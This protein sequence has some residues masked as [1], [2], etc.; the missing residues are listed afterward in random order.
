[1]PISRKFLPPIQTLQAFEAVARLC[2]FTLAADELSLTQ[3]AVSRQISTLETQLGCLLLTR[4]PRHVTLTPEGET[5]A[6]SVRSALTQLHHAALSLQHDEDASRLTLAILPTFGTRWLIPRLPRFLRAHP[7]ITLH[8]VT[9][10]GAF[11]MATEGVDAA[12]H[13]G[14]PDWPATRATL[15]MDDR[16]QP[17]AAQALHATSNADIAKLPRLALVSRPEEWSDW[18]KA[19]ELPPPEPPA[20]VFEHLA[21]MA[22]AC[23]A[24]FGAA[25]LPPFLF[26]SEIAEGKLHRL[27]PD[28]ANGAG[29]W[30]MEPERS[31]PNRAVKSL[32]DWLLTECSR[33]DGAFV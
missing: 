7:Q 22:Q 24:G 1:M 13:A 9:R 25:L 32:R 26:R 2:S 12:I 17:V 18:M 15:L 8:F 28:W 30:L 3:S 16:V 5:Y 19:H 27:A 20:M 6:R 4:G 21:A 29:Y 23:M 33:E 31:R 11:D 10:I 14:R